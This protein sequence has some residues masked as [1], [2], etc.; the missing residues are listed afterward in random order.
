[1]VVGKKGE[2]SRVDAASIRAMLDQKK[3]MKLF[4]SACA[5]CGLC[6]DSCFLYQ[7]HRDPTYTP[8]YKALNSLG[9]LFKK[10]GKVTRAAMVEMKQLVWGKCVLCRRCYCPF[11]IDIASMIA[12]ARAILR[13]QNIVERY[14]LDIRGVGPSPPEGA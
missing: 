2:A 13:T 6:A 10:R 8:A 5:A 1:M 11:G 3:Q 14:D 12:W 4:L 7:N 9:T